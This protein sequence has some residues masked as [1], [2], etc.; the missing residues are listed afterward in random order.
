MQRCLTYICP[1]GS[2]CLNLPQIAYMLKWK[3]GLS[4]YKKIVFALALLLTAKILTAQTVSIYVSPNGANT[5]N[6]SSPTNSVSLSRAC[7]VMNAF[8]NDTCIVW[9]DDGFYSTLSL[10]SSN[11]RKATAPAFFKAI[12]PLKAIFQPLTNIDTLNFQPIPNTIKDRIIDSVAKN[13]VKQ[14]PL[15]PYL[16]KNMSVWPNTFG[17][18]NLTAP[19]FYNNGSVLPM[20][21]YP[22]DSNMT[23]K[24]VLNNG[25]NKQMPGGTFVY[26]NKRCKYWLN[27]LADDGVFLSGAWRVPWQVDVVKTQVIDTVADTIQQVVG[28]PLGIGDKYARPAGNGKEPYWAINLVEEISKPGEWSINFKNQMLYM[29]LPENA[30]IQVASDA[31]IP[32]ISIADVSNVHFQGIAILGGAGDGFYL[33]NCTNVLIAGCNISNNA[34]NAVTILGGSNCT[35]QSNDLHHQGGAG[36]K[37]SAAN[38]LTDQ[39]NVT[40]CNHQIINNHIYT[41]AVEKQVYFPSIDVSTAIGTYVGY[42]LLNDAPQIGIYWGGNS[43]TIEYNEAYDMGNKY[44]GASAFYRTGNFADRGNK[45]R[46]NFVHESPFGGGISE[47]NNGTGDSIYY[48][49]IANTFLA[50]NNN[51]G[52]ADVFSNNIYVGNVPAHSSGITKDTAADYIKMYKNLQTI[53]IGSAAYRA[54]YPDANAMLDTV[55]KANK[56]F[57]SLQWNQFN[58]NVLY[59]N[60]QTFGGIKD[61]AFFNTNGSQKTSATLA[62]GA[63]F[64]TY[65]T[66]VKD[67]WKITGQLTNSITPFK[68]DSLKVVAA[69]SK[70]CGKDWHIHRIGLHKDAYRT[71]IDSTATPGV[72]PKLG[73]VSHSIHGDTLSLKALAVNPNIANCFSAPQFYIDSVLVTINNLVTNKVAYDTVSYTLSITGI[74]PGNHVVYFKLYDAPY[75]NYTAPQ[76]SFT[77]AVPLPLKRWSFQ[78]KLINEKAVL[79][80]ETDQK[81]EVAHFELMKSTDA[82]HFAPTQKINANQDAA[83]ANKYECTQPQPEAIAY[84]K[85]KMVYPDGANSFSETIA[86]KKQNQNGLSI[87]P[88]PV[89]K[90]LYINAGIALK[91]SSI[92]IC[93]LQG[94]NLKMPIQNLSADGKAALDVSALAAGMYWLQLTDTQGQTYKAK[95]LKE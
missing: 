92:T 33:K 71:N 2:H 61:T 21:R 65:G 29:W 31:T 50:T 66:I 77:I 86:L 47:D 34:G 54:A 9:L 74:A 1:H 19:K 70:P 39:K 35:V 51:G 69:F 53:Y 91:H 37:V 83:V 55:N 46:F 68:I 42:N 32:A 27:A 58:C 13:K 6:G 48:N 82:I 25:I 10:N 14:L 64:K 90:M 45:V 36:V 26:R 18:A 76:L 85:L 81:M 30:K 80:W 40:L 84:Y 3:K 38:Y 44:G 60:S 62:T 87:F 93:N 57:G 17:I 11:T 15:A 56:A 20:S 67:N 12:H 63:A 49:I 7:T 24:K 59:S 94:Q 72:A 73:W 5:G 23:M 75:W 78:V 43:H 88:N 4:P 41:V 95:F 89:Q 22:K 16:L 8:P 79:N 52:Y 28:I